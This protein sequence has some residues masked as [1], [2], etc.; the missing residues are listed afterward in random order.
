MQDRCHLIQLLAQCSLIIFV[1]FFRICIGMYTIIG[2]ESTWYYQET[3]AYVLKSYMD[4]CRNRR[5]DYHDWIPRKLVAT[6]IFTIDGQIFLYM[7]K[8]HKRHNLYLFHL[9]AGVLITL[10]LLWGILYGKVLCKTEQNSL[11]WKPRCCLNR[12]IPFLWFLRPP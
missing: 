12:A 9:L 7:Y 5:C 8:S 11:I 3:V 6:P 1:L 4:G 10:T 2:T